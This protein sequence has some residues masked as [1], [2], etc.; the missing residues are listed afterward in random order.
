MTILLFAID[1][2]RRHF[3]PYIGPWLLPATNTLM[4]CSVYATV[5]VALNRYME[6]SDLD[7]MT[8]P[9]SGE[10]TLAGG[11]RGGSGEEVSSGGGGGSGGHRAANGPMVRRLRTPPRFR[12]LAFTLCRKL[13]ENGRLQT[14]VVLAFSILFN[15]VR[16]FEHR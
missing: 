10:A 7:I 11:S 15:F 2:Y 13:L 3:F 12:V 16:F 4:T 8:G 6:M 9:S 14:F 1:R 5:M